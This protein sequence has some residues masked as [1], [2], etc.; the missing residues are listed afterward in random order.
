MGQLA[1]LLQNEALATCNNPLL[2]TTKLFGSYEWFT[3]QTSLASY[4]RRT[5]FLARWLTATLVFTACTV[6]ELT[7]LRASC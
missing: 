7:Q 5:G 6:L 4:V 3:E 2:K 1:C